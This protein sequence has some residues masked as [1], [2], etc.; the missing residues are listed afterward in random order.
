MTRYYVD[1]QD[2][3]NFFCKKSTKGKI[4]KK[5]ILGITLTYSRGE[6]YEKY[7]QFIQYFFPYILRKDK[8]LILNDFIEKSKKKKISIGTAKKDETLFNEIV[9]S[10]NPYE[11][12]AATGKLRSKQLKLLEYTKIIIDDIETNLG[13]KPFLDNGSLLG[14]VRHKG[15][16]PWDDDIDF[17]LLRNDFNTL[18]EYLK[19]KYITIDTSDWTWNKFYKNIDKCLEQYPNQTF[20]L[21]DPYTFKVI[22]GIAGDYIFIDFFPLDYYSDEHN[23]ETLKQYFKKIKKE[24]L[25]DNEN[26][27][28]NKI[29]EYQEKKLK[30]LTDAVPE[31]NTIQV[32][33]DNYDCYLYKIKGIRRKDDIFPLQKIKFEDTEF[34]APHNADAY[35]KTIYNFYKKLPKNFVI[36]K[37]N[38]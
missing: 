2:I 24:V 4:I 3:K 5:R 9:E 32:G 7:I 31:S 17:S 16:I 38:Y 1:P 12:P 28:F 22:N 23:V 36:A 21:K 27:A 26:I 30:E 14:A 25:K 37:H 6:F 33:I 19:S 35:L 15:F 20:V 13:I 11:L 29:F 18:I 10:I 34:W 8:E